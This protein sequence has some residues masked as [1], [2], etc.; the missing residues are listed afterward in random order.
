MALTAKQQHDLKKF[1][2]ELEQHKGRHTELITV[3]VPA[4]YDIV[5]IIQQ[6]EQEKGT[7][8]NIKSAS[9]RKNVI[10]ALERMTQHL[11]LFRKTPENGLAAFS[12]N[13]APEGKQDF[14]VWSLEP[15]I[16]I[17]TKIYRCDKTFQLDILLGMLEI[18]EIYGLVLMDRREAIIAYL[19]GKSINVVSKHT[20]NVPGKYKAGGQCLVNDSLVQLND[21]SLLPIQAMHNPHIVKSV[22]LNKGFKITNSKVTDKWEVKKDAVYKIVTKNPRLGIESSKDHMFFVLTNAG[23]AEKAAEELKHGD[24]LL[25]PEKISISGKLQKISSKKYYNSF[26]ITLKGRQILRQARLRKGLYQKQLARKIGM[27]QTQ[28]SWYEIGRQNAD[29]ESLKKVCNGLGIEYDGF[30]NRHANPSL[31]KRQGKI[32]LPERLDEALAQFLGYCTGDGSM[33]QDRITLFEQS[34]NVALAYIKKYDSYF[35]IRSSHRFRKKKNYHQIRYTSRP[36]VRL[37]KEEFPEITSARSSSIP[38]KILKSP[39][40]VV[41]AFLKGLF[42]AEGFV[43]TSR[44]LGLGINNGKLARQIQM[45]LLRFSIISSV[46]EY[47]NRRNTYSNNVRYTIDVTEKQSLMIFRKLIGFSSKIKTKKLSKLVSEKSN[48]SYV[49]QLLF[50]GERIRR[51]IEEAGYNL[52]SFPKVSSFFRNKRMMSKQTFKNSILSQIK[53]KQLLNKLKK[54]CSYPVIPVMVNKIGKTRQLVPMTDV[55]V[56]NKNFIANSIIVH[57]SAAR[58]G[59]IREN[60]AMEFYTRIGENVKEAFFGNK[61]LKGIIVGGPGPTKHEFVDGNF[62]T[63]E[64]KKK[65]IAIKDVT[66][67]DEFGLQELVDKSQD[68]LE[69]EEIAE[70]KKIMAKFFEYLAR[71]ESMVSYGPDYV[72]KKLKMGAVDVLLLSESLDENVIQ[73]FEAEALNYSTSVRIISTETREGIQLKE[74]GGVAAILR[75]EVHSE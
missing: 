31:G 75:Y 26:S 23:I 33:E 66:Y 50:A 3:Y 16:P 69:K 61:D 43:N 44:G 71:R 11:R 32:K 42:D 9:T 19:K 20:S 70:E 63:N 49:R 14:K 18:K 45:V 29:R 15:P 64:L 10:D 73:E 12:G 53:D 17:A 21:G 1:V 58:F 6:I 62:I 5:K 55:S 67:T 4:G 48:T 65:I 8:T 28:I 72:M 59:R 37:V 34:L 68:V 74:F 25:M 24:Y 27:D 60:A 57:N 54:I 39:D 36:L 56:Q 35:S 46:H 41:A 51:I 2:R 47:D 30:L 40:K 38:E 7:A 13:I 52:Q 22:A